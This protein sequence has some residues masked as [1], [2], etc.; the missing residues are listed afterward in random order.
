MDL[1]LQHG[2][3]LFGHGSR[4]E[5]WA[6]PF[7]RLASVV[8]SQRAASGDPGPV[9]LAFLELMEPDL[10]GAIGIQVESGCGIITVVPVF[11]GQGAHL[12]DD[13]PKLLDAC[14][15]AHPQIEIRTTDAVGEVPTVLAAI[16][17]FCVAQSGA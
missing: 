1:P 14:R 4:D 17:H 12:R 5:R 8:R 3:I 7:R 6:D 2:I 15:A 16:A 13:L 9:G 11:F 10:L